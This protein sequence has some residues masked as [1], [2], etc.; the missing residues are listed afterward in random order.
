MNSVETMRGS[1]SLALIASTLSQA[2]KSFDSTLIIFAT[3]PAIL[4]RNADYSENK[5]QR[6][7]AFLTRYW[8]SE[9]GRR[10]QPWLRGGL[11][12]R[13]KTRFNGSWKKL[14]AVLLTQ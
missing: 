7:D 3:S 13:T 6:H 8:K 9:N 1:K 2:Q 10:R 11:S 12:L 4:F 5:L 14:R